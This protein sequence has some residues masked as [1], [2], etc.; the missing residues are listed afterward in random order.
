MR[1]REVCFKVADAGTSLCVSCTT[2]P[3]LLA[4]KTQFPHSPSL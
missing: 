2:G 3:I 1:V 4:L